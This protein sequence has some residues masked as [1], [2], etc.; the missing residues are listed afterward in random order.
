MITKYLIIGAS[1]G[2]IGAVEGIRTLDPRGD[3]TVV[4]EETLVPYSRPSI[5]EYL[6]N[7]IDENSIR[8]GTPDFWSETLLNLSLAGVQSLLTSKLRSYSSTTVKTSATKNCC[9][10][11][12]RSQ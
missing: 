12:V 5:G 1:A 4:S 11:L 3:I 10:Q 9:L 8:F 6:D 7:R 2:A